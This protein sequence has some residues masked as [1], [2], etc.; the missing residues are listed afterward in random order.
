MRLK[1]LLFNLPVVTA[2]IVGLILGWFAH[3]LIEDSIQPTPRGSILRLKNTGYR[4]IDPMITCDIGP[5]SS[6]PE[7]VPTKKALND[8]VS[9]AIRSGRANHV[10]VY[11]RSSKVGRWFEINGDTTYAPASLLKVLIM[12]AYF[13]EASDAP[14]I[15]EKMIPFEGES[16][17]GVEK[18]QAET[19]QLQIGKQY[20]I[21]KIIE[22]MIIYSDNG[23][24]NTLVDNFDE[25][26]LDDLKQIFSDLNIPS[27]LTQ[28]E[29]KLNVMSVSSYSM[30]FRVLF[31]A[32]YLDREYSERALELLSRTNY[33]D[34]IVKGVPPN[35]PVAHKFGVKNLPADAT[36]NPVSELHD[37]GI[38]YYPN[39]PY[40]LCVMTEGNDLDALQSLIQDISKAAYQNLDIFFSHS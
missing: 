23:A 9:Q 28:D 7:L 19:P 13:K 6:F 22:Q 3:H 33:T 37:C 17:A 38:V 32:S 34:G 40:L 31:N 26:T 15:L 24:L 11:L 1:K 25:K 4:F 2:C 29:S 18:A 30:I 36:G 21:E 20:S 10:S 14:A 27:V 5:E 8:I 16:G 39:R 35:L 12:M